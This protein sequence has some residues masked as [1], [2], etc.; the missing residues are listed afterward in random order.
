M[1]RKEKNDKIIL[2]T[3]GFTKKTAREFFDLLKRA[4]VRQIIDIRL[5][6]GSQLSGFAKGDDLRFFLD[7]ILGIRYIHMPQF[8]PTKEILDD[9]RKG[10][11]SWTVYE[12]D[13]LHILSERN[14]QN[15]VTQEMLNKSCLL[16]SEAEPK[17]CHRR[18]VAE[19]LQEKFRN[20]EIMHL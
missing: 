7:A 5:K 17:H 3:I 19:Y 1:T 14:I 15:L 18:L 6:P 16:C 11:I 4:G 13:F 20:M 2:F 12:R 10:Q 8:A 9:Y